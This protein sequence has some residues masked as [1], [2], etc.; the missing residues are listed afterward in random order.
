MP[1]QATIV[2]YKS[3]FCLFKKQ[4][5]ILVVQ[6]SLVLSA[7]K[8]NRSFSVFV[9]YDDVAFCGFEHTNF[10]WVFYLFELSARYFK[11]PNCVELSELGLEIC[12]FLGDFF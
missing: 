10:N 9:E 6:R 2:L 12:L 7:P 11:L 5:R 3:E 8:R 1:C 4:D